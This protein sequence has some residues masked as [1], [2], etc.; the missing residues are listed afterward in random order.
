V[1]LES[2]CLLEKHKG[3]PPPQRWTVRF[4]GCKRE[5]SSGAWLLLVPPSLGRFAG[6]GPCLGLGFRQAAVTSHTTTE[7][8]HGRVMNSRNT[9]RC[10]HP[11]MRPSA[12]EYRGQCRILQQDCT[13]NVAQARE[14]LPAGPCSRFTLSPLSPPTSPRR[15]HRC[16]QRGMS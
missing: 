4:V 3:G 10:N 5:S 7:R 15:I 12:K 14:W 1:G 11:S 6:S 16:R 8:M 2:E 9:R 13:L